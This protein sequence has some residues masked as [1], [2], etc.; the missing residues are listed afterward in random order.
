[1]EVVDRRM[2]LYLRL[3]AAIQILIWLI[4]RRG[5]IKKSKINYQGDKM[6]V[7]IRSIILDTTPRVI[8]EVVPR[9]LL[10]AGRLLMVRRVSIEATALK[11]QLQ[12]DWDAMLLPASVLKRV[13]MIS[14]MQMD[15]Y[16]NSRQA[17]C[18]INSSRTR[19]LVI[20]ERQA[21]QVTT[22]LNNKYNSSNLIQE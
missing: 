6:W 5:P 20:R 4:I 9:Q 22:T 3:R 21:E 14:S 10:L 12:I 1:M 16:I 2:D 15:R 11:S 19:G 8:K 7:T 17:R 18:I 13:S